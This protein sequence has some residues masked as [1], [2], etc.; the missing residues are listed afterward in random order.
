MGDGLFEQAEAISSKSLGQVHQSLTT[1]EK[2]VDVVIVGSCKSAVE[3]ANIFLA[4]GKR[5]HWVIRESQQGVPLIVVDPD[6]RPNLL[7]VNNTRL[8][9][10]WSPSIFATTGF[11]YRFIHSGKWFVGNFYC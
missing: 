11:W 10:I 2:V 3:A 9:S 6:M 1:S 4:A 8:F 7:A 5:V